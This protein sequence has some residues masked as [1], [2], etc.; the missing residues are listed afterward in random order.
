M[1]YYCVERIEQALNDVEK[2]VR[3]SR[4]AILGVS[5]KGGV[6]DVRES[7]ALRI[8]EVLAARGAVLSYHDPFVP[9]LPDYDLQS[10]PLDDVLD[11]DAIVLVTAHPDLDYRAIVSSARLFIDLRG[12]TRGLRV[13]DLVR[14]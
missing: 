8:I 11:A 10:S 5:Y 2:P 4:I 9:S 13:E 7:P 12:K 3:G 14:L 1:P 6:G